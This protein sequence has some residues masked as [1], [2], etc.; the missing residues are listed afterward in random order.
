MALM[1]M[2]ISPMVSTALNALSV[3]ASVVKEV[4]SRDTYEFAKVIKT[5]ARE[6]GGLGRAATNAAES[7][8]ALS[9]PN[10]KRAAGGGYSAG[11][12]S[13]SGY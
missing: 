3:G 13:G 12:G 2:A 5:G 1:S 11:Y 10:R 7:A 6:F 9:E 4:A 8:G